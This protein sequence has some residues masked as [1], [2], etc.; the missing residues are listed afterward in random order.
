MTI[1]DVYK[2][3]QRI[4]DLKIRGGKRY[5]EIT[6]LLELEATTYNMKKIAEY[7]NNK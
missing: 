3:L 4:S 2:M 6:H 5:K 1:A 7:L